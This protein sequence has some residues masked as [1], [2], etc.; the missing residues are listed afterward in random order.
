[1]TLEEGREI[2][3]KGLGKNRTWT[4]EQFER[5]IELRIGFDGHPVYWYATGDVFMIPGGERVLRIE[6]L[7][8]ARSTKISDSQYRS[9]QRKIFVFR[10]VETNEVVTEYKGMKLKTLAY[11]YQSML[12]S[13]EDGALVA[14]TT[15]GSGDQIVTLV[16]DRFYWREL[17]DT[18]VITS[19]LFTERG[20]CENYDFFCHPASAGLKLPYQVCLANPSSTEIKADTV[21]I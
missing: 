15:M 16:G 20:W 12:Y 6:G 5:W 17:G 14:R 11:S 10:D 13:L 18:F 8:V 21:A 4:Q 3:I 2:G 7:D 19:P 9:V 1:M